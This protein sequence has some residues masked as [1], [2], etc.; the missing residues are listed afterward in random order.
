MLAAA[1]ALALDV[2]ASPAAAPVI[3]AEACTDWLLADCAR[4]HREEH[5]TERRGPIADRRRG[6]TI[7]L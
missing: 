6:P 2:L 1:H 7:P 5:P 3:N 4:D